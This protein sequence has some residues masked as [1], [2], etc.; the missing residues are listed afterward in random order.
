VRNASLVI[1]LTF[2]LGVPAAWAE[3]VVPARLLEQIES[4][5]APPI[6]DVRSAD[7]FARDRVPGARHAPFTD[8]AAHAEALRLDRKKPVVISCEH[9]PRAWMALLALR[10]AG[11][12]D[13]RLLA[14]HMSAWRQQ[15]LPVEAGATP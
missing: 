2:W 12:E 13:V 11:Y 9:G 7:E 5:T 15:G 3:S 10:S 8:V 14:G 4:K 1:A 6:L